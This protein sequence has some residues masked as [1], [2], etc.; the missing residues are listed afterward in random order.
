MIFFK[1]A[2]QVFK[3]ASPAEAGPGSFPKSSQLAFKLTSHFY[4]GQLYKGIS[5]MLFIYFP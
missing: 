4:V 1:G 2:T 5:L 3:V